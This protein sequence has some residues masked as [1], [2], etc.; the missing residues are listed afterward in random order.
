MILVAS[1]IAAACLFVVPV[2]ADAAAKVKDIEG[3]QYNVNASFEDNLKSLIGKRVYVT[4]ESGNTF[5]GTLKAVGNHLIHIEKM[6]K[7][8]FFDALIQIEDISAV[9]AKFRDF[10]R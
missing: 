1:V 10:E 7:K 3:M 8:D 4:M 6:D 9:D 5:S 2:K